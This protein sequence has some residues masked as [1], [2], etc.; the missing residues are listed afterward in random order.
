MEVCDMNIRELISFS[1]RL[2]KGRRAATMT[3]CLL[4]LAAELFFRFAEAA[5]Y[6]LLLYFGQM[7][8][9]ALF[10]GGS[11]IQLAVTVIAAVMRI[12]IAAPLTFAAAYR[13]MEICGGSKH[14]TPVSRILMSRKFFRKSLGLA[15]LS[16]AAALIALAPAVF[17]G[18]TAWSLFSTARTAGELFLTCHAFM[19]T[20]VSLLLWLSLKISLAAAPFLMVHFPE[21]SPLRIILLSVSFMRGKRSVLAGLA[22]VYLLPMLTIIGLPFAYTRLMTAAALS[23]SIYIKEDEYER[24]K[25]YSE[26][27]DACHPAKIP[28]GKARR[29]KTAAHKTKTHRGRY[30]PERQNYP[31]Y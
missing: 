14:V 30:Y 31:Q 28:H 16:K 29:I 21:Y 12:C 23:I 6:S 2:L 8:P 15:I 11:R 3:V 25:T 18:I 7:Q 19:L 9:A 10:S 5:V 26:Q 4:P 13:L 22:G 1:G 27:P 17:F 20:A 24:N